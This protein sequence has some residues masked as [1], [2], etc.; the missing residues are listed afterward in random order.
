MATNLANA[1]IEALVRAR[2]AHEPAAAASVPIADAETAYAVQDGVAR[3]FGWLRDGPSYW[4]SGGAS[5]T[6]PQTHALLPP[7]GVWRRPADARAWPFRL[8]GI[9]AEL[10]LRIGRDV[11][12]ALAAALDVASATALIDAICVSIEIVDSR[13]VEGL[14]AAPMSKLAD[15]QSHGA[16]VLGNWIPFAARDWSQQLCR[17]TVGAQPAAEFR[18]TPSMAD[19]AWVLPAGLRHATRGGRRGTLAGASGDAGWRLFGWDLSAGAPWSV[20][21]SRLFGAL[22]L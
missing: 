20:E 7:E 1:A 13:W 16:L 8:R 11:D 4:K 5:R 18:G 6:A 10:A 9:E 14:D 17:V 2:R 12:A 21:R 19:T 22:V 15:L 3:S